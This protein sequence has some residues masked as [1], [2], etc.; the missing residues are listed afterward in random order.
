MGKK[1][2]RHKVGKSTTRADR[3][4]KKIWSC[5][6]LRSR[7][8]KL[9]YQHFVEKTKWNLETGETNVTVDPSISY[10]IVN[11]ITVFSAISNMW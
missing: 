2:K 8:A 7:E 1:G 3:K 4:R 9:E 11:F 5:K 6:S 10:R